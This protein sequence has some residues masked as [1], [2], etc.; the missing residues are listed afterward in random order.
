MKYDRDGEMGAR[1]TIDHDLL[2]A[3]MGA[4][5]F[6]TAPPKTTGREQFGVQFARRALS[7]VPRISIDDL[8]AT[9]TALTAESIAAAYREFLRPRGP[10]DQVV[11]G[12]GGASNPFLLLLLRRL[13]PDVALLRHEDLGIDSRAKEAIGIAVIANDA[14]I[15]MNT[16]VPGATGATPTVL[17]K[18]CL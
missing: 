6:A 13:L 7:A 8:I 14:V 3:W 16:N 9:A 5:Y 1:G 10:I 17:G 11:V 2:A 15:G 12:G 18:I 4:P